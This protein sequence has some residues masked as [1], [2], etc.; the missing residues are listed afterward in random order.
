MTLKTSS[1]DMY[2][3]ERNTSGN[4]SN[5]SESEELLLRCKQLYE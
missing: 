4:L 5:A 2:L 3:L 1:L